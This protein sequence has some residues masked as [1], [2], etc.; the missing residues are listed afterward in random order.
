MKLITTVIITIQT[1]L[2]FSQVSPLLGTTWNQTCYYNSNCPIVSSGGSCG[3]AYTGCNATAWAQILKYYS[4]PTTG[5]GTHCNTVPG[6]STHCVDF[7]LQIYNY[8][9]M[10]NNV[11]SSNPEVA[12][13]M[14]HLGIALDMNWSGTNSTSYFDSQPL[15]KYFKYTPRMYNMNYLI[16]SYTEILDSIKAE[17]NVGRP[18]LVK[19]NTLNHFYIIDGYNAADEVHCNFGWGGTYDGYYPLTNVSIP[20]GN[21]TPHIFILNIRPLFGDLEAAED[22]IFISSA[23]SINNAIEFTSLLNWNMISP[24]PW[25]TLDTLNGNAGYF[26][27]NNG[28]TFSAL[29]NNGQVRYGYIYIQNASDTDT[30]VV[31]QDASPLQITPDSINFSNIGGTQTVNVNYLSWG[32]WN[33]IASDPW[34]N[35]SPNTATGNATINVTIGSNSGANRTGYIFFSGGSYTDTLVVNQD[36][37]VTSVFEH[38]NDKFIIYPNPISDYVFIKNSPYSYLSIYDVFGN[39]VSKVSTNSK[40]VIVKLNLSP[41]V[42]FINNPNGEKVEKIIVW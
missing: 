24:T 6:F 20:V 31:K 36:G 9:S 18:V 33:S 1:S 29:L 38:T 39:L 16:Q 32:T 42:Y 5:M 26:N 19:S 34:I 35:Y 7:S 4:Y 21:A 17:L 23:A 10:P 15:K 13:L 28:S 3:R 27:Q 37:N 22:T 14:Y 30:I 12:K 40:L 2:L 25:L 8:S 11:T 41:G